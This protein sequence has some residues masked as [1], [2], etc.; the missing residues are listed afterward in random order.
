MRIGS[1]TSDRESLT[2]TAKSDC[3]FKHTRK[4][5]YACLW[6]LV[7]DC[8]I[9]FIT[10]AMNHIDSAPTSAPRDHIS[11]QCRQFP[12]VLASCKLFLQM[13]VSGVALNKTW[14]VLRI[15][16]QDHFSLWG[17]S[18]FQGL[19]IQNPILASGSLLS[20]WWWT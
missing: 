6:R 4:G 14:D 1:L 12:E 11:L 16:D 5:C 19:Q 8:I 3:S 7:C 17:D 9:H 2:R 10:I 13:F 15:V 20:K 18:S